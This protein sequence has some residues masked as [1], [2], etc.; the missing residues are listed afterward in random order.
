MDGLLREMGLPITYT[1]PASARA[2]RVRKIVSIFAELGLVELD[3]RHPPYIT[4]K[5][6]DGLTRVMAVG[7]EDYAREHGLETRAIATPEAS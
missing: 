4:A 7:L 2:S 1:D 5:D 3:D 6:Y